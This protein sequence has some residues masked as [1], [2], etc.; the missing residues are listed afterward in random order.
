M[1]NGVPAKFTNLS[2]SWENLNIVVLRVC[3]LFPA[4]YEHLRLK[5]VLSSQEKGV[6]L[7]DLVLSSSSET[8]GQIVGARGSLNWQKT[9]RRKSQKRV[10]SPFLLRASKSAIGP[11]WMSC[12]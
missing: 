5:A 11:L 4:D 12:P 2:P 8:Q 9:N 7:G 3:T 10:F 1:M 6:A